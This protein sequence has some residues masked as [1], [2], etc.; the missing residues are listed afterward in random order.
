MHLKKSVFRVSIAAAAAVWIFLSVSI[1]YEVIESRKNT[2]AAGPTG[3]IQQNLRETVNSAEII[4]AEPQI[5][6]KI[7]GLMLIYA[8]LFWAATWGCFLVLYFIVRKFT[9]PQAG[10]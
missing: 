1:L 6:L 3:Y 2:I 8:V 9:D 4:A 10:R 7:F 5:I